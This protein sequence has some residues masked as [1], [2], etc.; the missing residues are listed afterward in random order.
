M[1]STSAA[2]ASEA[3]QLEETELD[4]PQTDSD[5]S[6]DSASFDP[7]YD[8]GK[9]SASFDPSYDSGDLVDELW[10]AAWVAARDGDVHQLQTLLL[11]EPNL[12][13]AREPARWGR[14][15]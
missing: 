12:A 15:P 14:A 6:E 9:D 2:S 11:A 4:Q 8:S 13:R 3:A 5:A 7:S 10:V 1:S